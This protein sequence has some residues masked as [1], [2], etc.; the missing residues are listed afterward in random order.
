MALSVALPV[1]AQT[2]I[3]PPNNQISGVN[4]SI[5]RVNQ[6]GSITIQ[7]ASGQPIGVFGSTTR[8]DTGP[9]DLGAESAPSV[10]GASDFRFYWDGA[11]LWYSK[12]GGTYAKWALTAGPNFTGPIT[13]TGV[14]GSSALTLTGATQTTS[15]PVLNATQTWNAGAVVFTG[16]KLNITDTASAGSSLLIDMQVAGASKFSVDKSGA[17]STANKFLASSYEA[18]ASFRA[19][20]FGVYYGVL[21][22]TRMEVNNGNLTFYS[23]NLLFGTDNANDLGATAS[24]RP[25]TGYFGTSV[26]A[27]Q[28]LLNSNAATQALYGIKTDGTTTVGVIGLDNGNNININRYGSGAASTVSIGGTSVQIVD[29]GHSTTTARF[30][31]GGG[32][33][34]GA[35]PAD[36]GT[37]NLAARALRSNAVTFTNA[38]PSPVEGT[39]QAFTDSSTAT[40]GATI[41]GGGANHVLGYYNGTNWTVMGK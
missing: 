19:T 10:S 29:G 9:I 20:A 32:V 15:Q 16:I 25:R 27:P 23:G 39:M 12:N 34:L 4:G 21:S 24:G 8:F 35:S 41:T 36:P 40:W 5:V 7:T 1:F 38:I 30:Y 26:A 6:D 13:I 33:W 18:T 31:G 11:D 14:A 2:D 3:S 22:G 28:F 17:V 37:G